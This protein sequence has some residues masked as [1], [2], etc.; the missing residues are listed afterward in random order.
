MRVLLYGFTAFINIVCWI[1][2]FSLHLIDNKIDVFFLYMTLLNFTLVTIYLTLKFFV[3]LGKYKNKGNENLLED[4]KNSFFFKLV[5]NKL[6]KFSFTSCIS[7][8]LCY[9]LLCLGG[10]DIMNLPIRS[11]T[12]TLMGIY[13]HFV[14]GIFILLDNLYSDIDFKEDKF[15]RDI[16]IFLIFSII[17]GIILIS[18]S[19]TNERY[20]IYPFLSMDLNL[21]LLLNIV[22]IFIYFN[23][24]QIFY[25]IHKKKN[26]NKLAKFYDSFNNFKITNENL[27]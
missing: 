11:I 7:V 19:K 20:K 12:Q 24:Y 4:Q 27:I 26:D 10:E 8:C 1:Y 13:L 2:L 5:N 22:L 25:F 14:V 17:Y 9:W 16:S 15:L 3:E 23:S 6:S 18:L 21:I